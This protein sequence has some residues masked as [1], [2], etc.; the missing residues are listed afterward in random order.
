MHSEIRKNSKSHFVEAARRLVPDI[1]ADNLIPSRKVGIRS[2]LINLRTQQLEMDFV[3]E[4][5]PSSLHVLNAISPAFTSSF[6][7]AELL[8]ERYAAAAKR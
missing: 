6:A 3:I 7:F 1:R 4:T 8:V 5:T 2:Q